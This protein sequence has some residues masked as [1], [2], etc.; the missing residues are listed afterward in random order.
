MY[1]N[2]ITDRNRFIERAF[3]AMREFREDDGQAF[4]YQRFIAPSAATVSFA[5]ARSR[6]V[7]GS[8]NELVMAATHSLESSDVA[9]HDMGF[10]LNDFLLSSVATKEDRGYG[11]PKGTFKQLSSGEEQ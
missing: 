4:V 7:T 11:R 1:G 9:P 2:G 5:K 8:M 6:S 10:F 3:N